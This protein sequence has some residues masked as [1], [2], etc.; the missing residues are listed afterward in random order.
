[1]TI[2]SQALRGVNVSIK[3]EIR[4]NKWSRIKSHV[5]AMLTVALAMFI[6]LLAVFLG[7]TW[8]DLRLMPRGAGTFD[9]VVY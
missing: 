5:A 3:S 1:V 6:A 4:R 2:K 8:Q 9:P 7:S